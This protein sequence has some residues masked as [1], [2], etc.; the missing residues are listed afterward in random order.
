LVALTGKHHGQSDESQKLGL[1]IVSHLRQRVDE[2][3]QKYRL[4][5][6]CYATPAEGLSDKFTKLDKKYLGE[7]P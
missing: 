2:Y 7:I 6:S 4:N 5:F 3:K 1:K